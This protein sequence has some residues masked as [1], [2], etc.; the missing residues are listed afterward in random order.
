MRIFTQ[1]EIK[2][3]KEIGQDGKN[4]KVYQMLDPQLQASLAVKSL[5]IS[6]FSDNSKYFDE[7]RILYDSRHVNVVDVKFASQDSKNIYIAM[8]FY[9]N[10]SLK[11]LLDKRFLTVREI[12]IIGIDFLSGLNHIHSKNL[13]HFDVKP[14]NI[15]FDDSGRALIGDFGLSKYMNDVGIAEQ[16]SIYTRHL[17]PEV[18]EATG[19]S[20]SSDIY[21]AGIT[22]YR[23]C[24]GEKEF[25]R[26][27]KFH[28]EGDK[29]DH[30]KMH[31]AI[32]KEKFPCRNSYKKHI[33]LALRK[34]INKA[35]S[36]DVDKR[37]K[38]MIDFLNDLAGIDA[39]LDWRYNEIDG[40]F[41][42]EKPKLNMLYFIELTKSRAVFD[43]LV[44]K[45]DMD[46]GKVMNVNVSSTKGIA[47]LEKALNNAEKTIKELDK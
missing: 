47:T 11:N 5:E 44:S 45:T 23:M 8:P 33:P 35:I 37:H 10:G 12:I 1:L 16:E 36:P 18:F 29:I 30:K 19:R 15:L 4:S 26:Q 6:K 7:A 21:Q 17:P 24:N 31:D 38:S 39:N 41:S 40:V 27:L 34:A 22:L 3:L 43:V 2:L 28:M 25:D 14:S 46:S 32:M 20:H 42:W 13:I 9:K